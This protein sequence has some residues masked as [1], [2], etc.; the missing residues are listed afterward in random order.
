MRKRV[1]AGFLLAGAAIVAV[2]VGRL[3]GGPTRT[4]ASTVTLVA[5]GDVLLDRG[6]ARALACT[7]PQEALQAVAPVLRGADIAF[8]NLECPIVSQPDPL[9]KL[10]RFA[11]SPDLASVLTHCGFDIVSLANNHTMDCGKRGLVETMNQLRQLGIA[12]CGAGVTRRN[13]HLPTI[14]NKN[15]LRVAFLAYSQFPPEGIVRLPGAPTVALLREG[16]LREEISRARRRADVVV[17][18]LHWGREFTSQ[19][20]AQQRQLANQAAAAGADLILGHHPHVL[21]PVE[22]LERGSGRKAVVAYSLGNFMFDSRRPKSDETVI[23]ECELTSAGI[24][25]ARTYP[26]RIEGCL[27]KPASGARGPAGARSPDRANAPATSGEVAPIKKHSQR[28][29]ARPAVI[30][31]STSGRRRGAP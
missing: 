4:A 29:A 18:S 21:Q 1:A 23:L 14:L 2:V 5:V 3:A 20:T 30:T 19:P 16:S 24:R 17:V 9:P 12:F 27:P 15:G 7:T 13:A 6:V 26:V 10:H 22:F 31:S 8:C 25:R 11:A 28:P